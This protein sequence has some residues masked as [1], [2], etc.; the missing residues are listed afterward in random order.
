MR[1]IEEAKMPAEHPKVANNP[2]SELVEVDEVDPNDDTEV[3]SSGDFL[4][5]IWLV[6]LASIVTELHRFVRVCGL[7]LLFLEWV[8]ICYAVVLLLSI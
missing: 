6:S 1:I 5:S 2:V 7:C 8:W 4:E 3:E